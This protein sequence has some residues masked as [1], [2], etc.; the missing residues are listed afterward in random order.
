MDVWQ[1]TGFSRTWRTQGR[2]HRDTCGSAQRH[3]R[4]PVVRGLA[5]VLNRTW[6]GP[7]LCTAAGRHPGNRL[8]KNLRTS[9]CSSS[10]GGHMLSS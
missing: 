6:K 9:F 10:T 7:R 3:V 8:G 1:T 2:A 4:V 5:R